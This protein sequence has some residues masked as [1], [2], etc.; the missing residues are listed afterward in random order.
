M[1]DVAN[2][3]ARKGIGSGAKGFPSRAV[4]TIGAKIEVVLLGHP[5]RRNRWTAI[6]AK[7]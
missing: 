2:A 5:R 4:R 3:T 1:G 6:A 7:Q